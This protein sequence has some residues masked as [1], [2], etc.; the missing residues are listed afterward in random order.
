VS[1]GRG[2]ANDV[3]TNEPLASRRHAEVRWDGARFYLEDLGSKNGTILN[4]ARLCEVRE[5]RHGDVITLPGLRA[6]FCSSEETITEVRTAGGDGRIRVDV[7]TA[8]VWVDG[9]PVAVSAKEFL[10]LRALVEA[11]GALV[12]KDALSHAA[13][14]EYANGVSSYN[15]EQLISRLRRKLQEDPAHPQNLLTVRGLGYRLRT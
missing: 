6:V 3:A 8:E 7:R 4:G 11:K 14:P 10:A 2:E 5:L 15:I 9:E 13:W 12:D 1:L